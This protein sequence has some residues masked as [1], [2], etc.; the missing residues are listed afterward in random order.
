MKLLYLIVCLV[1]IALIVLSYA[2]NWDD[3]SLSLDF[4]MAV[5]GALILGWGVNRY[6]E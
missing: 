6:N 4:A 1:G 2:F 5:I 3:I